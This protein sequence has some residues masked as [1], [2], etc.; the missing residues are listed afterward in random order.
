MTEW[1][2]KALYYAFIMHITCNS[3]VQIYKHVLKL[4]EVM[5]ALEFKLRLCYLF[6]KSLNLFMLNFSFFL[7]FFLRATLAANGGSQARGL[8]GAVAASHSHSNAGS[9]TP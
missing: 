5:R 2:L 4:R 6:G 7:F 3:A 9:L 1:S 8:M